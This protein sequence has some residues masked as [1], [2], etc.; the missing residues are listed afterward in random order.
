LW[1]RD[2]RERYYLENLDVDG[3]IMLSACSRNGMW[4][5]EWIDLVQGKGE[6]AF[7]N[8]VVN[9]WVPYNVGTVLDSCGPVCFFRMTLLHG[10]S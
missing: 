2:L 4:D 6:V 10:A 8:C 3:R 1:W 7:V 5:V 9:I